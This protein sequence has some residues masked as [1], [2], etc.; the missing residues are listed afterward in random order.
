MV[1]SA[2]NASVATEAPISP[3]AGA[4]RM[5]RIVTPTARPPGMRRN[6]TRMQSRISR[7]TPDFS[8]ANPMKSSIGTAG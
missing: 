1:G 8:S 4:K 2:T 6:S 7:A 5:P 3:A